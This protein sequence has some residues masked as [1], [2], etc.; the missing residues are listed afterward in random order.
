MKG[1]RF[2]FHLHQSSTETR[3]EVL[4]GWS[5]GQKIF[6]FSINIIFAYVFY[7]RRV[8][9]FFKLQ[10]SFVHLNI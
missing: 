5:Q 1:A 3:A 9:W 4:R 8:F 10:M 2:S 6:F 7:V